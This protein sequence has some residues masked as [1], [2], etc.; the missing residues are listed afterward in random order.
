MLEVQVLDVLLAIPSFG[1]RM[2]FLA[3]SWEP[4]DACSRG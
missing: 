4:G 3:C 2:G 1:T